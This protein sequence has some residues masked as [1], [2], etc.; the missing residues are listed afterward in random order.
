MSAPSCS[1]A[2]SALG[3]RKVPPGVAATISG[4]PSLSMSPMAGVTKPST[5]VATAKCSTPVAPSR[6]WILPPSGPPVTT[7]MS[8]TSHRS[9]EPSPLSSVRLATSGVEELPPLF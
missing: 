4:R 8:G 3:P 5:G 9:I 1:N 6:T 7:T 2:T